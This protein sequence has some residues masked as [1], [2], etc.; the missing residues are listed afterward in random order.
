MLKNPLD[1]PVHEPQPVRRA[2][3][4]HAVVV[5]GVLQH[6]VD[7]GLRA[8]QMGHAPHA[9]PAGDQAQP[10]LGQAEALRVGGHHAVSGGQG[11]LEAAAEGEAVHERDRGDLEGREPVVDGVAEQGQVAADVVG[12]ARDQG[13][14]RPGREGP[15]HTG[16]G[17]GLDLARRGPGGLLVEDPAEAEERGR[18]QGRGPAGSLSVVQRE[19]RERACALGQGVVGHG[20]GGD[21]LI[22]GQGGQVVEGSKRNGCHAGHTTGG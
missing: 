18:A 8:D 7:G 3:V 20:D 10:D 5:E 16:H 15:L 4:E 13:Q 14:V 9:G 6:D 17:Q 11:Q 12:E 22:R 2:G 19:Q 21:D 1:D